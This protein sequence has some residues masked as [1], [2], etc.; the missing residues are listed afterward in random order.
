V[1]PRG[2]GNVDF[3]SNK[4][5][6]RLYY[7]IWNFKTNELIILLKNKT[8]PSEVQLIT[9]NVEYGRNQINIGFWINV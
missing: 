6:G 2:Y 1:R 7:I 5:D 4:A 8:I 9:T 3:D